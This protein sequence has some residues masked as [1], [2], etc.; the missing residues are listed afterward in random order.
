MATAT[1]SRTPAD[2][3]AVQPQALPEAVV[4][5]FSDAERNL[6]E[7][8]HAFAERA[9]A[10][11]RLGTGEP[12]LDHALGLAANIAALK[13]D[14]DTVAAGLLFA[15]PTYM[16]GGGDKLKTEFGPAVAAL[17]EGITRLNALRVVTRS[18]ALEGAAQKQ[19]RAAAKTAG[20][21]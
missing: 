3:A 2:A 5:G 4:A 14:A 21:G 10:N 18:V 12:A 17:V 9:Y 8:A 19:G 20:G 6:A 7:R 16:E 1:S 15:V 13:L 11:R